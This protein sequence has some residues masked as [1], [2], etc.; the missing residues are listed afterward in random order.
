MARWTPLP[1]SLPTHPCSKHCLLATHPLHQT[2]AV[3]WHLF[4][5]PPSPCRPPAAG[6]MGCRPAAALLLL[7]AVGTL[8]CSRT[9]TAAAAETSSALHSTSAADLALG[10]T[11]RRLLEAFDATP[12]TLQCSAAPYLE[13][14]RIN[15]PGLYRFRIQ[16]LGTHQD[17][18]GGRAGASSTGVMFDAIWRQGRAVADMCLFL[19]N[20]VPLQPAAALPFPTQPSLRALCWLASRVSGAQSICVHLGVPVG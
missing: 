4:Q 14:L 5:T 8:C 9:C 2:V 15:N 13:P 1:A 16:A 3:Q 6:G 19:H 7:A 12:G 17:S 10:V 11:A 18:A 20:D